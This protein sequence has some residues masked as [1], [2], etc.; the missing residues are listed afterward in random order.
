VYWSGCG[1]DAKQGI[2]AKIKIR[3]RLVCKGNTCQ[4]GLLV[5]G[6]AVWRGLF[7]AAKPGNNHAFT[8][9]MEMPGGLK[10][11]TTVVA[12]PTSDPETPGMGRYGQCELRKGK[13]GALHQGV[14]W[15]R[16]L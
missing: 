14:W 16:L 11:I 3:G 5:R 4:F 6:Q 2:N 8:P 15:Q 12:W 10:S 9:L 1:A 7:F 13:P